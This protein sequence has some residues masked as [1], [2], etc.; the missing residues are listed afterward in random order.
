MRALYVLDCCALLA[1]LG[2]E[3]GADT[4]EALLL[5]AQ[6]RNVAAHAINIYELYY[7]LL[8]FA[9]QEQADRVVHELAELGIHIERN[10]SNLLMHSAAHFKTTYKLSVADSIALAYAKLNQ[11]HL[12]TSDHHEMDAVDAAG[13][14]KFCWFR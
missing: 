10:I 6:M 7:Q 4:I 3:P 13:E 9:G 1:Y 5:R 2:D 11:A 12:V 14:V 8:R